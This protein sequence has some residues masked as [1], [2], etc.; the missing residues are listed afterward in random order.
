[1]SVQKIDLNLFRVFDAVMRHRSVSDAGRELGVSASAVSHALARL[2][3]ALGDDLFVSGTAGMEPTARALDLLPSISDGLGRFAAA[4]A[5]APFTPTET[6]RTFRIAATDYAAVTVLPSLVGRLA[7]IAPDA[8]LRIVPS[9]RVD[10]VQL[11]DSGRVDLVLGWF[12]ELPDRIN[13]STIL[14]EHEAIV[15]RA[16]HPLTAENVTMARVFAF[17]HIVVELTGTEDQAVDG[18]LDER[19][20]ARRV[21]IERIL[22]ERESQGPVA[23]VAVSVPH[24]AAVPPMLAVTDMVATLPRRLA[25][26]AVRQGLLVVLDLPH[27]PLA[28]SVESIR[29]Q[30]SSSDAGLLWLETTMRDMMQEPAVKTLR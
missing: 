25:L 5:D 10:V 29:H 9:N 11:L 23:R 7:S 2:R 22:I 12:G 27:E 26:Q 30:R 28:V 6:T 19:G 14:I 3:L 13:R 8:N 17:P 4:V 24:Y 15:V 16:G 1:M 20:V 18:F 21:W